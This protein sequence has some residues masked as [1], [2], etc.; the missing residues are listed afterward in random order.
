MI[1][2]M[3]GK[4]C[5]VTGAT[6]GIGFETAKAL[7]AKGALVVLVGRDAARTADAA[8]LIRAATGNESVT[9]MIADLARFDGVRGLAE[10]FRAR[11]DRLDVLVNN[12]GGMTR[13]RKLSSDGFEYMWQLNHLGYFLLTA[14]LLPLL[15]AAPRGRIVNVAST[16]H[17]RGH[18][19]FDDLQTENNYKMWTAYGQS[20]LA[21]IMFTYALARR[22]AGTSV[23]ANCLH[24][25]VVASGFVSNIGPLESLLAPLIKLFMIS[26]QK[27]AE[28]SVY[29]ASAPE[30]EGVNGKYFVRCKQ[31][32][33]AARSYDEAVQER[34]W[35]VSVEQSGTQWPF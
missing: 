23:T 35:Q 27:G 2:L 17:L 14:E 33:S 4:I 22:L 10:D 30:V 26:P 5:L 16:A 29:L 34:L 3:D 31:K 19:N 6:Q 1:K 18:I 9:H 8:D 25:G 21:N 7:A 20:K 12:A 15:Q 13:V 32:N 24:P 11:Y 28:T